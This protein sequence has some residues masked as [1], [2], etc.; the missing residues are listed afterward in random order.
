MPFPP[1]RS[2]TAQSPCTTFCGDC[3]LNGVGPVIVDALRAAQIAAGLMSPTPGQL[4]CCDTNNSGSVTVTD[5][6]LIAQ[7][8]AGI[9]VVLNCP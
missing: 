5:A 8:A 7:T 4:G 2:R 6:L 9:V 1:R 3:D